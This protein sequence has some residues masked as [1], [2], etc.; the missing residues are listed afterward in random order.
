MSRLH[1]LVQ[2]DINTTDHFLYLI[3]IQRGHIC[4]IVEFSGQFHK[5][6]LKYTCCG[7][8]VSSVSDGCCCK[9][10]MQPGPEAKTT[11]VNAFVNAIFYK[12][13]CPGDQGG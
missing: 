13:Q 6:W 9:G 1:Y 4:I 10:F 7:Q 12:C 11:N 2:S 3:D 5:A 8:F